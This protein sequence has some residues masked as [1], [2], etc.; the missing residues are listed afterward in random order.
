MSGLRRAIE[1]EDPHVRRW[2]T[3]S[4]AR[5]L[6]F[7]KS[8]WEEDYRPRIV[9]MV[10]AGFI[11][12][13]HTKQGPIVQCVYCRGM[14]TDTVWTPPH[15]NEPM[16]VHAKYFRN[17]PLVKGIRW[18]QS[19]ELEPVP[20]P[21]I[22]PGDSENEVRETLRLR[23]APYQRK[24][25]GYAQVLSALVYM[26]LTTK[27]SL[28]LPQGR[29]ETTT[30]APGGINTSPAWQKLDPWMGLVGIRE[31]HMLI[32][33]E[34]ISSTWSFDI[35]ACNI[36]A[37][38]I[39]AAITAIEAK[40]PSRDPDKDYE[41]EIAALRAQ[42]NTLETVHLLDDIK[43]GTNII[44]ETKATTVCAQ[45]KGALLAQTDCDA[46]THN[47]DILRKTVTVLANTESL[48]FVTADAR[49]LVTQFTD[50]IELF[51]EQILQFT[52]GRVPTRLAQHFMNECVDTLQA[53]CAL[54]DDIGLTDLTPFIQIKDL[55]RVPEKIE[56]QVEVEIPCFTR[57]SLYEEYRLK[58]FPFHQGS[59]QMKV[60]LPKELTF[61]VQ[62]SDGRVKIEEVHC[63]NNSPDE[64]QL[65]LQ[66][67]GFADY[68]VLISGITP[69]RVDVRA[70]IQ[71]WKGTDDSIIIEEVDEDERI[72]YLEE[73][74]S[75][76]E[77]CTG[78]ADTHSIID[79]GLYHVTLRDQCEIVLPEHNAIIQ[80]GDLNN[81]Y[82]DRILKRDARVDDV[83][84]FSGGSF[85]DLTETS[86]LNE[87][88]EDAL[89]QLVSNLLICPAVAVITV[90][91]V[92]RFCFM[93][94]NR[95]CPSRLTKRKKSA[96]RHAPPDMQPVNY[97]ARSTS[98]T[99]YIRD[100]SA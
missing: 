31:T 65:C 34:M 97:R 60:E 30:N 68:P 3:F 19:G 18:D 2:L 85:T 82:S 15:V 81:D 36:T 10:N 20:N 73:K 56:V 24:L 79:A 22:L 41:K 5:F 87:I 66:D 71:E 69:N 40:K 13:P 45:E 39:R 61:R 33:D 62:P 72:V 46:M 53:T 38:K 67:T 76:K 35:S 11:R 43:E 26:L 8:A 4:R 12:I 29:R 27:T 23:T 91:L 42:M 88:T 48:A 47:A 51:Q 78:V 7:T 6:T 1:N 94:N 58:S 70:D 96:S 28:A 99:V 98:P 37:E 16:K 55:K 14:L 100:P 95:C 9:D 83:I 75:V 90:L 44:V 63:D 84:P 21:L 49:A 92:M 50:E 64:I 89:S 25:V 93:K 52:Q 74:T 57:T 59:T 77:K 17:C 86:L 80:K 32:P 54:K